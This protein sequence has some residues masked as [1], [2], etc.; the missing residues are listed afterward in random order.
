MSVSLFFYMIKGYTVFTF[1]FYDNNVKRIEVM[2]IKDLFGKKILF[3]DGAMG[4]ML[5]KSGLKTGELPETLNITNSE[6]VIDIH[7]RYLK[8]G[9]DIITANT[10]GAY[11]TKYDNVEEI[12]KYGIDNVRLSL[13]WS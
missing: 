8:A 6:I 13:F 4:S 10:F 3:F 1:C 2:S 7:M 12:I 9:A 5:Q 11:S